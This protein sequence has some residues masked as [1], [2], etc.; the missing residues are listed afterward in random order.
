MSE[1]TVAEWARMNDPVV[2]SFRKHGGETGRQHPVILL[3]TTGARTGL[4]RVTP[5]NFLERDGQISVIASSGGSARDPGWY[6]NLVADP[7]VTIEHAGETFQARARTAEEPERTR[8]FDL[9]AAEMKFFDGY[10]KRVK[11]RQI[12]VVVFERVD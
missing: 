9:Q 8:L 7:M 5:L 10:R 12:P 2:E 4:P 6:R 1:R 3:T 11:T